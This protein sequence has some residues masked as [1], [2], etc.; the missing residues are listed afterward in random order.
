M[1]RPVGER[2]SECRPEGHSG[3]RIRLSG[4]RSNTGFGGDLLIC[5]Y[6]TAS[7]S[8]TVPIGGRPLLSLGAL[9]IVAGVQLMSLGL[10]ARMQVLTRREIAGSGFERGRIDRVLDRAPAEDEVPEPKARGAKPHRSG[11]DTATSPLMI[12]A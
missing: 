2:R 11:L 6:L 1:E 5:L 10:L 8:A 9:L 7:S 12:A 3:D 4:G